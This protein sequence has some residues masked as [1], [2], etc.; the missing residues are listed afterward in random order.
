MLSLKKDRSVSRTPVAWLAYTIAVTNYHD[1]VAFTVQKECACSKKF[2][3]RD[4]LLYRSQLLSKYYK[5]S[6]AFEWLTN[7]CKYSF[8]KELLNQSITLTLVLIFKVT[9]EK[10]LPE[11]L[12]LVGLSNLNKIVESSER[13]SFK[14]LLEETVNGKSYAEQRSLE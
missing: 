1:I 7:E 3:H 14:S 11:S 10:S 5:L 2:Y 8:V 12:F 6:L 4:D 13:I 9:L